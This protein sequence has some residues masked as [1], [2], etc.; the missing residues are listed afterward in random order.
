M[1]KI[2]DITKYNVS[3]K[4]IPLEFDGFKIVQIT[5]L[6]NE[7]FGDSNKELINKIDEINPDMV[8]LTG[9]LIIGNGESYTDNLDFLKKI[10]D[11][12][13]TYSVLGNHEQE[14]MVDKYSNYYEEYFERLENLNITHLNNENIRVYKGDSHINIYGLVLPLKY[15]P[16][17]LECFK[18]IVKD[19][20]SELLKDVLGEAKK[21]QFNILLAHNPLFFDDYAKW[22]MDLVFSGHI[23]GGMIR[24]PRLGGLL[25][26]T[27]RLFPKYDWG[28]FDVNESTLILS[29]GLGGGGF[30]PRILCNPEVM[31]VTLNSI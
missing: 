20:D 17:A 2:I 24:I 4:K 1:T 21:N 29:K 9:D 14:A 27:R 22:D 16:N 7:V 13:D 31:C 5:D 30:V 26:P 11:K 15:Y 8:V 19:V 10:S 12:Y 3:N 23:H 25:S 6:H 28:K 18:K